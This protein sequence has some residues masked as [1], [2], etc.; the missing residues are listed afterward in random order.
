[1]NDERINT[2]SAPTRQRNVTGVLS[3][4]N[5]SAYCQRINAI[6]ITFQLNFISVVIINHITYQHIV[7]AQT[8]RMHQRNQYQHLTAMGLVNINHIAHNN[9]IPHQPIRAQ[10]R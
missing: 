10:T 5:T 4:S 2:L 7:S 8:H 1:M 9:R 3:A 6:N